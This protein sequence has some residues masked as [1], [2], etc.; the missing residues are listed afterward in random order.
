MNS[1]VRGNKGHIDQE[2]L[3]SLLTFSSYQI[4]EWYPGLHI[5]SS[6]TTATWYL[7]SGDSKIHYWFNFSLHFH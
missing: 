6:T 4:N 5:F 2:T 1:P 3:G 7:V